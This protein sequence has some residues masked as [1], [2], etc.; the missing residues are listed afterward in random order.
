MTT[1][2]N[3]HDRI[4]HYLHSVNRRS[5]RV[6]SCPYGLERPF[7]LPPATPAPSIGSGDYCQC[8]LNCIAPEFSS[9]NRTEFSRVKEKSASQQ[10]LAGRRNRSPTGH[11]VSGWVEMIAYI[12]AARNS[13]CREYVPRSR[14]K[15]VSLR[16]SVQLVSVNCAPVRTSEIRLD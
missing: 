1:V 10:S 6:A 5:S 9:T 4:G 12:Q 2:I 15:L 3:E 13:A 14:T 8:P 7:L 16:R 11:G